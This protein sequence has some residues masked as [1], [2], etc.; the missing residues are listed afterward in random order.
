MLKY[1]LSRFHLS[2]DKSR[3]D[4]GNTLL[5]IAT[6]S[7]ATEIVKILLD[8]GVNPNQQNVSY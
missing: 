4:E 8:H 5:L 3:D 1:Y 7:G 2:L 6:R